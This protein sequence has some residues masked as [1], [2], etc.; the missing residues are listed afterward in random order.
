MHSF[1]EGTDSIVL[2][3]GTDSIVLSV[4]T[5]SIVL[6]FKYIVGWPDP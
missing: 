3:V 6:G 2:S 5:D 4:G 1:S